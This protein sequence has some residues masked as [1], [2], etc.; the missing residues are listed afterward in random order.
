[1]KK[2]VYIFSVLFILCV[3]LFS[4]VENLDFDQTEDFSAEPSLVA[5]LA[6]FDEPANTFIINPGISNVVIDTVAVDIFTDDF[7]VDNLIKAELFFETTN[8]I[9]NAFIAQIDFYN[10]A[11][12]LQNAITI[13]IPASPFNMQDVT[14]RLVIFEDNNL[15]TFKQSTQIVFT[16]TLVEDV[17]LLPIDDNTLGKIVFK[18]KGTFFFRIGDDN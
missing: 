2:I 4:C 5:S 13:D 8:S 18:S 12:E 17:S 15:E 7:V 1:M 6:F 16:L 11:F 10:N 14:E 3:L 9:N